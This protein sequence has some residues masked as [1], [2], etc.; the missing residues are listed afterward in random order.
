MPRGMTY[1]KPTLIEHVVCRPDA[2][3]SQERPRG[4]HAQCLCIDDCDEID[5]E[6]REACYGMVMVDSDGVPIS[7][8]RREA[9]F[10]LEETMSAT[11][12]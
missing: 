8:R 9:V 7:P 6:L 12:C 4:V 5:P 3:D 11:R 1:L 2:G 10:A